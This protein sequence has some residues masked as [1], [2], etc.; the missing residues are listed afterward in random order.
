MADIAF[1]G[2]GNMG[3]PMAANLVRAG[4]SVCGFDLSPRAAQ[5]AADAGVVVAGSVAEAVA[6]AEAVFTSLPKGAH[7]R[8]VF[9]G[10]DGIWAHAPQT[11][12]LMD[13]STVDIETSRWCHAESAAR[14][15]AFA[16]TPVSGGTVGAEAGTL[17]V[18]I[19]GDDD[20]A[21]RASVLVAPFAGNAIVAGGP[22][23]GIAAK[24]ANNMMLFIEALAVNE[25]AVLA[26]RLGLDP[27]VF[28]EIVSVSSG[29]C[30]AQQTWYPVPGVIDSAAANRNFEATFRA[31][32]ALKDVTLAVE[33]ADHLGVKV[34]AA[35]LALAQQQQLVEEGLGDRDCMLS[36][37]YASPD[38]TAAG[39]DPTAAPTTAGADQA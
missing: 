7:V 33:A 14:G 22:T 8:S 6:G 11:A 24:L 4:H 21:A 10:P 9:D 18:M 20:A 36:V 29:R 5:L 1:I 34:P 37:K 12:L 28:W 30:W 17:A 3:G 32:L 13:T 38:G 2:L 25:G 31:D 19:G 26:D 23:A 27:K 16:D 15:F 39:W 35:K